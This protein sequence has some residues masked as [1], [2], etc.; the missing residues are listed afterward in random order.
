MQSGSNKEAEL[1]EFWGRNVDA[2]PHTSS[3]M[4]LLGDING[5]I[6]LNLAPFQGQE[7]GSLSFFFCLSYPLTQNFR[8]ASFSLQALQSLALDC[9]CHMGLWPHTPLDVFVAER[10]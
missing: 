7:D 1:S 8:P 4:G 2:S 10:F 9:P 5:S 3:S 6:G